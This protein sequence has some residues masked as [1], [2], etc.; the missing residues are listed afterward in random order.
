[1]AYFFN[2]CCMSLRTVKSTGTKSTVENHLYFR[3]RQTVR[4]K[5]NR[6]SKTPRCGKSRGITIDI[7][8]D[9]EL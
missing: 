8:L 9:H 7:V 4:E 1:M 5:R 6:V 3:Y 2:A